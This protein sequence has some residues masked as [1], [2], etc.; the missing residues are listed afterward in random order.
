MTTLGPG[1][2]DHQRAVDKTEEVLA[3][4]AMVSGM[5]AGV[6]SSVETFDAG[7]RKFLGVLATAVEAGAM[8]SDLATAM[9]REN[10]VAAGQSRPPVHPYSSA[11]ALSTLETV[12]RLSAKGDL[13]EGWVW[14]RGKDKLVPLKDGEKS[15]TDL[16]WWLIS[17][18]K[19][20]RESAAKHNEGIAAADLYGKSLVAS[21]IS[22]APSVEKAIAALEDAA[23]LLDHV[24]KSV[25]GEEERTDGTAFLNS[26]SAALR[27]LVYI[28]ENADGTVA[29][30]T[31]Y[32]AEKA[33]DITNAISNEL[34]RI[35][36]RLDN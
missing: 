3:A 5:A 18:S 15:I 16:I 7:F 28:N 33:K 10:T 36:I 26:L 35:R 19:A 11:G 17:P 30:P 21:I 20:V 4:S 6:H 27:A 34:S 14:R 1:Y 9:K 8:Y 2:Y 32:Q 25:R 13:P 24:S 29:A 22:I 12:S 23:A 31:G